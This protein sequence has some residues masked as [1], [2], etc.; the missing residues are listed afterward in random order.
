[1]ELVVPGMEILFAEIGPKE[2]AALCTEYGAH[3]PKSFKQFTLIEMQFC[4]NTTAHCG[5]GCQSGPC[6]GAPEVPVPGPQPAPAAS[7]PGAFDIV[8]Q[9][10]VPAMHAGLM[11][12]GR[13]IFLDKVE[14]YTQIK[15]PDGQYAYSAEYDPATNTAVGLSYKVCH[16]GHVMIV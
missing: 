1:M 16:Y 12:N 13:V 6:V 15:L 4:G 3:S 5:A 9:A 2:L 8:G 7:S 11:P 10:G 14:N